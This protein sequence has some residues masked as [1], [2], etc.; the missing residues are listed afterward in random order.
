[1]F[2]TTVAAMKKSALVAWVLFICVGALQ[3]VGRGFDIDIAANLTKPLLMPLLM[4]F[5]LLAVGWS[6]HPSIKWLVVG[7]GFSFLG[8]VA[9]M[10]DGELWFGL[11]IAMFLVT[12]VCYLVGFFGLGARQALRKRRWVLFVYP[13]FWV[14]A[15][16]ALWPGLGVMRGPILVY[17]AF[18]VTMALVSMSLGTWIGIGGTLFM[19]SD[20]MIGAT[21]AYGDFA[22]SGFLIMA[23]Y[24]VGQGL[25]AWCW[26]RRVET[27]ESEL[28][29]FK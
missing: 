13:T 12:H 19:L 3:L 23:T 10:L 27:D 5:V 20:L 17:S 14:V 21:V 24:I 9:L 6:S 8:D 18:L 4:T 11:G 7:Q 29:T 15:N 1:M 2:T 26:V 16:A 22:A 25:I 28:V